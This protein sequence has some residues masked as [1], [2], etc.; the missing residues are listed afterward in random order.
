MCFQ[1]NRAGIGCLTGVEA[2]SPVTG[3]A[4]TVTVIAAHLQA[5]KKLCANFGSDSAFMLILSWSELPFERVE[6]ARKVAMLI[7][8]V[9]N[10]C[11]CRER[12]L[13]TSQG[14]PSTW[15]FWYTPTPTHILMESATVMARDSHMGVHLGRCI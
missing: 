11:D 10:M 12:A 15:Y 5:L 8:S 4:T 9:V 13:S 3:P 6:G 14:A 7:L 2:H 1:L